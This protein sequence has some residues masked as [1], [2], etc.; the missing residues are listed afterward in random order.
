MA[1]I[2]KPLRN[3]SSRFYKDTAGM[4][5]V[6]SAM[7]W[8]LSSAAQIAA[9]ACN[10]K[11]SKKEKSFLIPQEAWDG[12]T[13]VGL[14]VTFSTAAKK[15]TSLALDKEL[16]KVHTPA[17]YKP[18]ILTIVSI[19]SG[20]IASNIITPFVRNYLGADVQKRLLDNDSTQPKAPN[21]QNLPLILNNGAK[22]LNHKFIYPTTMRTSLKI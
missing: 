17:K 13:N 4:L 21:I 8:I 7:G 15:L 5:I 22:P 10:R 14:F 16:I 19:L 12:V 20:A 2:L 18:P 6:T 9:I 1:D 11:L 3:L